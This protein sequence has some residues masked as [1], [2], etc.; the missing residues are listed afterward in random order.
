MYTIYAVSIPRI[1][2]APLGRSVPQIG[3]GCARLVGRSSM[4][5]SAK[6]IE[7]A[8]DLGI[9]Y[10][11]VAPSYGMGT[12]EEVLGAVLGNSTDVVVAT[13]VGIPRPPYSERANLIRRFGKPVLDRVR[14]LKTMARR[15]YAAPQKQPAQR[16]GGDFSDAAIQASIEESLR[17]LK[18]D[19]LDVYLAH[20][21]QKEDLGPELSAK[22]EGLVKDGL[23]LTYGAGVDARQDCCSRFGGSVWQ[24]G[25]PG[26]AIGGYANDRTY[27][28][29][30]TIRYAEKD[31]TGATV[32]PA[33]QLVRE[34]IRQAPMSLVLVSLS[35][36]SR[37]RDLV[38]GI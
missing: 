4:K 36:P 2:F 5:Q 10:F 20:E 9:R 11:D 33:S 13:K 16:S 30:G 8:L 25:W 24:S 22:F 3:F 1:N 15:F 38:A 14:P 29:H 31:R 18:R 34:A 17:R 19:R 7:T 35:T 26:E 27:I 28:F 12:A 37:L 6:M 32:V 21:P 23:I